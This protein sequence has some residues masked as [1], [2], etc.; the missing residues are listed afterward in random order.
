M[1]NATMSGADLV[2][3]VGLTSIAVGLAWAIQVLGFS[4]DGGFARLSWVMAAASI[5]GAGV[6]LMVTSGAVPSSVLV[7][8]KS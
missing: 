6:G 3:L 1:D 2:R 8:A 4:S 5:S 7:R